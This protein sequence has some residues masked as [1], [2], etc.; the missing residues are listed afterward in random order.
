MIL[1]KMS[2]RKFNRQLHTVFK[3]FRSRTVPRSLFSAITRNG[4]KCGA[5]QKKT[6]EKHLE[7]F[8][9][10]EIN[11]VMTALVRFFI[12]VLEKR[13]IEVGNIDSV[14]CPMQDKENSNVR[15]WQLG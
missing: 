12:R 1:K 2:M 4:T 5:V 14:C 6:E 8:S 7:H 3:P 10:Q 11:G 9:G 15:P 13:S